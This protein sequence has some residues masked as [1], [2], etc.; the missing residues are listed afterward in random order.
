MNM[1]SFVSRPQRFWLSQT[2]RFVGFGSRTR[3][4]I[5]GLQSL[6]QPDGKLGAT[7]YQ[8]SFFPMR[9]VS[10]NRSP[11]A[12]AFGAAWLLR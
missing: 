12:D 8:R 6:K 4:V 7:R 2:V 1:G 9:G 3:S 5:T 11:K 10:F